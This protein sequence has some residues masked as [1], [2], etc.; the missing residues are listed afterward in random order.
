MSRTVTPIKRATPSFARKALFVLA[1]ACVA[2]LALRPGT[3]LAAEI[4]PA[5]GPNVFCN[6][7][8]NTIEVAP[9]F[10]A[11][12]SYNRQSLAYRVWAKDLATNRTFWLSSG[13]Q[14]HTFFHIRVGEP[15]Y[16]VLGNYYPGMI[17][18]LAPIGFLSWTLSGP[19]VAGHGRQY[20]VFA[21]HGWFS[22][23]SNQ[24]LV[25]GS[26]ST[27]SYHNTTPYGSGAMAVCYL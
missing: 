5:Y 8:N 10:G 13:G 24:W 1:V 18:T 6:S 15:Y 9:R 16:D 3:A 25:G 14:W 22:S 17:N 2:G 7:I 11:G 21:Q 19:D 23:V 27:G 26:I 20:Q 4:G 12:D